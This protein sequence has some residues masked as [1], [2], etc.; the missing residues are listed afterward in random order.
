[1]YPEGKGYGGMV[2]YDTDLFSAD[3]VKEIVINFEAVIESILEDDQ[4]HIDGLAKEKVEVIMGTSNP[5]DS[6][7]L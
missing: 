7:F 6:L 4:N 1:M 3:Y 5:Q 2:E